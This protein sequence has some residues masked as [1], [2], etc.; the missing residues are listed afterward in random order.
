M[1][2]LET[3]PSLFFCC[4]G[5]LVENGGKRGGRGK[6]EASDLLYEIQGEKNNILLCIRWYN[7]SFEQF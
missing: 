6:N 2:K 4:C 3:Q 7:S 1:K 5:W